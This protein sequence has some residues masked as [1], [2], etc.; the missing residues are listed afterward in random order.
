MV[1]AVD[2]MLALPEADDCELEVVDI[3]SRVP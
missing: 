3:D 1:V 2:S